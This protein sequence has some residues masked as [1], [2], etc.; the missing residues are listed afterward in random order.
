MARRTAAPGVPAGVLL[1]P[2]PPGVRAEAG[3][4]GVEEVLLGGERLVARGHHGAAQRAQG[5][6]GQ[7][8]EAHAPWSCPGRRVSA[9]LAYEPSFVGGESRGTV[10][11]VRSLRSLIG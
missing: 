7:G 4:A 11:S 5:Q 8:G 10:L 9:S 6:V 3:R 1:A 2:G